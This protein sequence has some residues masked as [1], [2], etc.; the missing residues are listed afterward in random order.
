MLLLCYF[1]SKSL[2]VRMNHYSG[3]SSSS[4]CSYN[5]YIL[6]IT[7]GWW[8]MRCLC[9]EGVSNKREGT[10]KKVGSQMHASDMQALFLAERARHDEGRDLCLSI[11]PWVLRKPLPSALPRKHQPSRA[12]F[13]ENTCYRIFRKHLLYKQ[14]V[15]YYEE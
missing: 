10:L 14:G 4:L 2:T 11:Y 8:H 3:Y 6:M 9:L 15:R 7:S 13:Y 12:F 1:I 5:V